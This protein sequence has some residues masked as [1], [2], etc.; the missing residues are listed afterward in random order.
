[1]KNKIAVLILT[2]V[3]SA[4]VL[5]RRTR[6]SRFSTISVW[7]VC[8]FLVTTNCLPDNLSST[9][10]THRRARFVSRCG[11]DTYGINLDY[12]IYLL[13]LLMC[14]NWMVLV[15]CLQRKEELLSAF[16]VCEVACRWKVVNY[17][18]AVLNLRL[19]F[20]ALITHLMTS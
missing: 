5:S 20:I 9:D 17:E 8:Q 19:T 14:Y 2:L 15:L 10:S 6:S 16:E 12:K 7:K 3:L 13:H 11:S 4:M 1:M 18:G